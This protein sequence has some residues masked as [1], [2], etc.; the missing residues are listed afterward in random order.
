MTLGVEVT[1]AA[2]AD[3]VAKVPEIVLDYV[4][5]YKD[6]RPNVVATSAHQAEAC[7][8][9]PDHD[10]LEVA[11]G[12]RMKG[13]DTYEVH[14][15][16][17]ATFEKQI[18]RRFKPHRMSAPSMISRAVV[19]KAG[20][21]KKFPNLAN[22]VVNFR[23]DYALF[24]RISE[25]EVALDEILREHVELSDKMLN[26]VPCYHVYPQAAHWI[27]K[28]G[29]TAFSID[30]SAY[31]YESHNMGRNRLNE[32]HMQ[33]IVFF[34]SKEETVQMRKALLT[35]YIDL[36][37]RWQLDFRAE[38]SSDVFYATD[39]GSYTATQRFEQAKIELSGK[40]DKGYAAF[41]SF[42]LH[43]NYYTK[44]FDIRVPTTDAP[45]SCCTGHGLERLMNVIFA[46]HGVE[47]EKWP[48]ALRQEFVAF[49][50]AT[51]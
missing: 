50:E 15:F 38:D 31:R 25:G 24:K 48:T 45:F 11:S 17:L 33:E 16:L 44:L 34:G 13:G 36:L 32:F 14:R 39:A 18:H 23:K 27:S 12:V 4:R 29:R 37:N 6:F 10:Y 28:T 35:S 8:C 20:Y 51:G 43:G 7:A 1:P 2:P 3:F 30:G 42:N 5:G 19:E 26:P 46:Q 9:P 22:F 40:T 41:A 49:R 21:F 47:P